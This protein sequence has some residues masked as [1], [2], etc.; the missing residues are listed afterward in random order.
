[1][2][3]HLKSHLTQYNPY[4]VIFLKKKKKKKKIIVLIAT[5]SITMD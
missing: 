4:S 5:K 2:T 1:M 3:C